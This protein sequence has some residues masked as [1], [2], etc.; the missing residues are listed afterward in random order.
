MFKAIPALCLAA[1]V[2]FAACEKKTEADALG[3]K[4]TLVLKADQVIAPGETDP[5]LVTVARSDFN[6]A[7]DIT[8]SNLPDGVTL[9]NPGEIPSTENFRTYTLVASAGAPPVDDQRVVVTAKA[10]GID[11]SDTIRLTVRAKH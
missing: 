5:V 7:V 6:G 9:A 10:K 2:S 3:R 8:F 1:L 11:V 4:L